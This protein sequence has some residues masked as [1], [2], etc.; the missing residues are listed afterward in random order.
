MFYKVE[1]THEYGTEVIVKMY[2]VKATDE[3]QQYYAF[4]EVSGVTNSFEYINEQTIE[5][6][7]TQYECYVYEVKYKVDYTLTGDV[8]PDDQLMLL[9]VKYVPIHF[10]EINPTQTDYNG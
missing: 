5:V 1:G 3:T 4:E 2:V 10:V 9:H 8:G 6:K 7:D